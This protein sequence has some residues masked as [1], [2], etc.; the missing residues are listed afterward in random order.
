MPKIE[1]TVTDAEKAALRHAAEHDRLKLATWAKMH[2]LRLAD[3]ALPVKV[4][5]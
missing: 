5:K 1:L 4:E 3:D 2:L